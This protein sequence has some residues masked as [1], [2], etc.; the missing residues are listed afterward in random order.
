MP[1]FRF[2]TDHRDVPES[3][4]ALF[5]DLRPRDTAVR[6]LYLRQ[7][8]VLRAYHELAP[9]PSNVA[10]ELPTGAGKTLVGLLIAEYRRRAYDQRVAFLCP[11]V[12]LARQAAAKAD[13]Y[14]IGA[15]ALVRRQRDWDQADFQRYQRGRAIAIS[16]YS[17]VFNSNPRLDSAQTLILD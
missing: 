4:E 17:A 16:T 14:G 5:R 12:Q 8:D 15:V 7:G 2:R 6:D 10:L 11:N 9:M 1:P 3:P 13:G